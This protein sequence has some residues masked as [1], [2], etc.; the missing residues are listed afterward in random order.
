MPTTRTQTGTIT[1]KVYDYNHLRLIGESSQSTISAPTTKSPKSPKSPSST[2][3]QHATAKIEKRRPS[4]GKGTLPY[5]SPTVRRSSR[6]GAVQIS[7]RPGT[8]Y[9]LN[10]LSSLTTALPLEKAQ[11]GAK[12]H[13]FW[14]SVVF[15][16]AERKGMS[17]IERADLRVEQWER[18]RREHA[19]ILP[20]ALPHIDKRLQAARDARDQLGETKENH[21]IINSQLRAEAI[22]RRIEVLDECLA[23]S[24]FEPER[25]NI[26][27][28]IQAYQ[29]GRIRYSASY[30]LLW[31]GKVVDEAATYGEFVADRRARLDRYASEHGPHWLWFESPL[32]V[33]AENRPR[34]RKC[35]VLERNLCT[36]GLGQYYVNQGYWKQSGWVRRLAG[37]NVE[38]PPGDDSFAKRHDGTVFVCD[39][40][41]KLIYRSLLDSGATYPSLHMS[42]L[43]DLGVFPESY[44]AQSCTTVVTATGKVSVRIYELYVEV[45]DEHGAS[46]VDPADPTI[47]HAPKYVGSLCPVTAEITAYEPTVDEN[48]ESE[49]NRV[50][51]IST[52]LAP[53]VSSTPARNVLCLG[54]DRNDVLGAHKMPP[55][56]RWDISCSPFQCDDRS[57]WDSYGKPMVRFEHQTP[58]GTILDE[59]QGGGI[60]VL[61]FN[62]GQ[63]NQQSMTRWPLGDAVT[64]QLPSPPPATSFSRGS[65]D[66]P[67]FEAND[68]STPY[69]DL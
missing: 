26:R 28:A 53:Y 8:S 16:D 2:R 20:E 12:G 19:R 6:V 38:K 58:N 61:T 39:A 35:A 52:L 42:D 55:N 17:K 59:D 21:T 66:V 5:G 62:A 7:S 15:G 43:A 46:L 36:S 25:E 49:D 57:S 22:Q 18:I 23:S 34:A 64:T 37:F 47:P 31:A 11:D 9:S 33:A 4:R 13:R 56:R 67:W 3:K 32:C 69:D 51:G 44:G 1:P 65:R 40:G 30:T 27:G 45:C 63:P 41:P 60:S 68:P 10:D 29:S 24:G 54:E 14:P 50:A 48:G